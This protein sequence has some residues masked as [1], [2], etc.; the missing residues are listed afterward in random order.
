VPNL[1]VIGRL[2]RAFGNP[3]EN[4]SIGC[5]LEYTAV[6]AIVLGKYYCGLVEKGIASTYVP[7]HGRR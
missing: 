3:G 6:W 5:S 2:L 7:E 4:K 1:R